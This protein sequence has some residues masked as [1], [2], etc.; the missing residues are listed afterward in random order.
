M[1]KEDVENVEGEHSSAKSVRVQAPSYGVLD[2]I[3]TPNMAR[4][5]TVVTFI[6]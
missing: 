6:W 2:L 4:K 3:K 5:T 1:N